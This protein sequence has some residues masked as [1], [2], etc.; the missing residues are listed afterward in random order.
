MT[1]LTYNIFY[2]TMSDVWRLYILIPDTGSHQFVFIIQ[3][4]VFNSFIFV[5]FAVSLMIKYFVKIFI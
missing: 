1:F 2:R 4:I 5:G 3:S